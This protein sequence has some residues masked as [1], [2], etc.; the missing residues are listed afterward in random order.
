MKGSTGR[1]SPQAALQGDWMNHSSRW[2]SLPQALNLAQHCLYRLPMHAFN[3]H[4]PMLGVWHTSRCWVRQAALLPC[5]IVP[6]AAPELKLKHCYAVFCTLCL[7][8][9]GMLA[10][11]T[12]TMMMIIAYSSR[13]RKQMEC[14]GAEQ[15]TDH[16]LA[17]Q[18]AAA[19]A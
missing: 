10:T 15:Q 2:C 13:T 11:A 6:L 14:T 5:C 1:L 3:A 7:H 12:Q 19:A 16:V 17:P 9:T 18:I 4:A 8:C